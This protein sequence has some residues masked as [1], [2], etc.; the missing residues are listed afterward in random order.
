MLKRGED[1]ITKEEIEKCLKE[2]ENIK[3]LLEEIAKSIKQLSQDL[4]KDFCEIQ[5][6]MADLQEPVV[7]EVL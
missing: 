4:E 5:A 3:T 7:E 2:N 6:T 1:Q